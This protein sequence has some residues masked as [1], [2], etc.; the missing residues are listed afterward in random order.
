MGL[1]LSTVIYL[2]TGRAGDHN[3]GTYISTRLDTQVH[4]AKVYDNTGI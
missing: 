1:D 3:L 2:E 4:R